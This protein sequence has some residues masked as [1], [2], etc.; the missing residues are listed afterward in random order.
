MSGMTSWLYGLGWVLAQVGC[1]ERGC[2][3][4]FGYERQPN[5]E[6]LFCVDHYQPGRRVDYT[7]YSAGRL[8]IRADE[9][10]HEIAADLFADH[11]GLA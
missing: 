11:D 10:A 5:G 4:S 3:V 2:L 9:L 6:L 8:V 1:L 7:R